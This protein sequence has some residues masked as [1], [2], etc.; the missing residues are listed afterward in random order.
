MDC[1]EYGCALTPNDMLAAWNSAL[2]RYPAAVV[3]RRPERFDRPQGLI[4]PGDKAAIIRN[5]QATA[6][7]SEVTYGSL[8]RDGQRVLVQRTEPRTYAYRCLI[9]VSHLTLTTF[10]AD[11]TSREVTFYPGFEDWF[12]VGGI[13]RDPDVSGRAAFHMLSC[14]AGYDLEPYSD[15]Q[16]VVVERDLWDRWLDPSVDAR[17]FLFPS[18]HGVFT[19][20][21]EQDRSL[22][23][24]AA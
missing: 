18:R 12:C 2:Y 4:R 10:A 1:L 14:P 24:A 11:G 22:R 5:V 19:T 16:P 20:D 17:D 21:P 13:S 23:Q 6:A 7:I 9:P 8:D 3:G 15:Q